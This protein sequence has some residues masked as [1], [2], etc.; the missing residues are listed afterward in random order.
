[1]MLCRRSIILLVSNIMCRAAC[2]SVNNDTRILSLNTCN[3]LN[4]TIRTPPF[5]VTFS[6]LVDVLL[7]PNQPPSQVPGGILL[8]MTRFPGVTTSLLRSH[9]R[10]GSCSVRVTGYVGICTWN[11]S[12][13][14]L[15]FSYAEAAE[16]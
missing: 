2:W 13:T 11:F 3:Q 10:C 6:V 16:I 1:M 14:F 4:T 15:S 9:P 8:D 5:W 12:L 7:P